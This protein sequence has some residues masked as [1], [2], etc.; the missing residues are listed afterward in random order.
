MTG[1]VGEMEEGWRAWLM[2]GS[3]GV[4]GMV[5]GGCRLR[6][7]H[8]MEELWAWW[9]WAVERDGVLAMSGC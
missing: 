6:H 4:L 1:T 8:E 7:L 9:C 2:P 5:V 3:P